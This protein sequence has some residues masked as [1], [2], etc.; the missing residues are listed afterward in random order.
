MNNTF[1]TVEWTTEEDVQLGE[2]MLEVIAN[3]GTVREGFEKYAN[4]SDVRTV[5]ASKFRFF[6]VVKKM[7]GYEESYEQAR[8]K[9]E[10]LRRGKKTKSKVK[11]SQTEKIMQA[12]HVVTAEDFMLLAQRFIEQQ[13]ENDLE[14][15]LTEKDKEVSE[16]KDKVEQLQYKLKQAN[17]DIDELKTQLD[18][19]TEQLKIISTAFGMINNIQENDKDNPKPYKVDKHSM[20]VTS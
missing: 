14:I 15:A 19:K 9:G 18:D 13:K 3:G 7:D 10:K 5:T 2:T 20:V 11:P 1:E 6:S 12:D 4:E 17:I 8:I 16:L